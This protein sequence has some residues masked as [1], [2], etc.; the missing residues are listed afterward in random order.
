MQDEVTQADVTALVEAIDEAGRGYSINLTRLVDGVSTYELHYRGKVS[1]H[2]CTDDAYA[3]LREMALAEKVAAAT[4]LLARH[5][6]QAE[7]ET[8]ARMGWR[9]IES[10]PYNTPV[11]IK[12]G[13]MTFLAR[14]HP[15]A[16]MSSLDESCD[17]WQAEIDGEHPPCWSG[18]ACWASNEN[19]DMSL[20]PTAW[21]Y[22]PAP[23]A[24]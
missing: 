7:R 8:L 9:D 17:Q 5:R 20:Q 3:A 23:E 11:E 16:S 15:D 14:L 4:D 18:G 19:E 10:A 13:S 2:E 21:R 22:P 1:E 6:H 24:A 12:V